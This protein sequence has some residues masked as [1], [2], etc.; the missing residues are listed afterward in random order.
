MPGIVQERA[1]FYKEQ[2]AGA[3]RPI[4]YLFALTSSV[5]PLLFITALLYSAPVYWI[6]NLDPR[7]QA[8]RFFFFEAEYFLL[9]LMMLGLCQ[10]LAISLPSYD[11]ANVL[12]GVAFSLF[13][14]FAGFIIPKSSIP[15]Y[16]IWM[17]WIS[18]TRYPTESMSVNQLRGL[19]FHCTGDQYLQVPIG[20]GR[21]AP[22]C[23]ITSGDQILHTFGMNESL[24]WADFF[25]MLGIVGL[26]VV[27]NYIALKKIRYV[28]T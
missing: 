22:Y 1:V 6:T 24:K 12:A 5:V 20:D 23:Q 4:A 10:F 7:A 25:I 26:L 21:T 11:I 15:G 28:K 27:V 13:G 8:G 17:Y 3:Y 14:L 2:A 18:F 16:F 9:A 19:P